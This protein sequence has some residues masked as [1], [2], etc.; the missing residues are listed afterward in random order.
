MLH[1]KINTS[2]N[3][4]ASSTVQSPQRD[5]DNPEFD[6]YSALPWFCVRQVPYS[7]FGKKQIFPSLHLKAR[8]LVAHLRD[9]PYK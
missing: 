8:T 6:H 7:S 5:G 4:P 2:A 3:V 9:P 1:F